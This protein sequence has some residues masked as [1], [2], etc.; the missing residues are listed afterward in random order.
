MSEQFRR[1]WSRSRFFRLALGLAILYAV[2]RL[3]VHGVYLVTLLSPGNEMGGQDVPP[4]PVDLQVYLD[5]A[6]H[7][8]QREPLYLQGSLESIEYHYPYPPAYALLFVPFLGWPPLAASA[9]HSLVHIAAYGLLYYRWSRIFSRPGFERARAMLVWTTP[10]WLIWTP[11]WSD[12]GYLN[13]YIILAL[14][15]TLL[16]EAVLDERLGWAVL[17]LSL[18]LQA[19]PMWAFAAA[20]PLLLGR[21]RFFLRLVLLSLLV[22]L[23]IGEATA[24]LAG[25]AYVW[26]QYGDYVHLLGRLGRDFPWRGPDAPFLGY[27]HSLKQIFAYLWGPSAGVLRLATAVKVLL[28]LPLAVVAVRHLRRPLPGTGLDWAFALYLGAFIWLDVV[29]ELSLGIAVFTYLLATVARRGLRRFLVWAVGLPYALVDLFQV[30]GFALFGMRVVLP[31][32]YVLTDPSLHV[33][34]IMAVILTFYGLLVERLWYSGLEYR[35]GREEDGTRD[36]LE[37][38]N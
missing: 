12:L 22:Y 26:Q 5:A 29:W 3:V 17:W 15:A 34:L 32:P 24:L 23:A 14:L 30:G 13:I 21:R 33:P 37:F 1:A 28:L 11:F 9:F 18:I 31:G 4:V 19:K 35:E 16:I 38:A 27:N 25:P 20:V 6:R 2:L 36:F 10:V 7:F 8:Q